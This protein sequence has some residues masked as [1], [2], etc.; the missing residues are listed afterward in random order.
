MKLSDWLSAGRG[1]GIELA[2][3]VVVPASLV[4]QWSTGVRPVPI[5]RCLPIERAT[6]GAVTRKDLRPADWADIWPEAA[7]EDWRP[8]GAAEPVAAGGA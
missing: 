7:H 4:S 6:G 3:A 8:V 1:R 2:S 5:E